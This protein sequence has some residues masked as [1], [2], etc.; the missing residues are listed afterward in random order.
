MN[1]GAVMTV[2]STSI[3]KKA[4][5]AVTGFILVGFVI[6]HMF[7][8]LKIYQGE[9]KFNAYAVWLREVGSPALGHEQFLWLARFILLT[10]T[11]LHIVA[12]A[13]LTQMSYAA[14]PVS[15][16][17]WKA[18]QAT[19]ASRTMRW[20]GV[21]I[22]L[23][24]IYHILHFTFGAVGFAPGQFREMSVYRN[25]V[26]GFSA[27]Y[28]T[29]FYIAAMVALGLHMYH[30]VWSMF[31]TLGLNAENATHLYRVLA[32]VSSVVVVLGNISVPISVL[33]GLIK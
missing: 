9:V 5:M 8:N 23:F 31:Q 19:Y 28:V 15:Y 18:V 11:V 33:A 13:Q 26:I 2:W 25:V 7:G 10:A 30:G 3:G 29:A 21:I 6:G 16:E 27:W 12:A 20:G 32:T 22:T 24:V 17:Q 4:V 1:A 14:R